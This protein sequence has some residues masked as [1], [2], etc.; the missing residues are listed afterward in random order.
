M[1]GYQ[2]A[3]QFNRQVDR[4]EYGKYLLGRKA[5]REKTHPKASKGHRLNMA[6]NETVKLFLAHFWHVARELEGLSTE[7]PY[8]QAV[9]G[10]TGIIAPYYFEPAD[11]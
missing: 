1:I 3:D 7:G 11:D 10:H 6:K 4:T 5:K 8:I 9:G 2:I